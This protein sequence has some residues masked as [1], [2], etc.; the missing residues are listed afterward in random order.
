MKWKVS[1]TP[2][3]QQEIMNRKTEVVPKEIKT[4]Y[5]LIRV[6]KVLLK[7]QEHNKIRSWKCKDRQVI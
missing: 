1:I 2:L 5:K 7:N 4:S 6:F 3:A